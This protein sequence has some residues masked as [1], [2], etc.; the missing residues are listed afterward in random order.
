MVRAVRVATRSHQPS[1]FQGFP[2]QCMK[3]GARCHVISWPP[4]LTWI[5]PTPKKKLET[6]KI[7]GTYRCCRMVRSCF[8]TMPEL[9]GTGDTRTY[10]FRT[11][12]GARDTR[13]GWDMTRWVSQIFWFLNCTC[14]SRVIGWTNPSFGKWL[15]PTNPGPLFAAENCCPYSVT[16]Q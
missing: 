4:L 2:L 8:D 1:N 10:C 6:Q 9:D 16:V 13:W 14:W 5:F 12:P 11:W 7:Q 15:G 3:F